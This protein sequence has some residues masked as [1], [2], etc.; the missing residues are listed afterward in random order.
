MKKTCVAIFAALMALSVLGAENV[1]FKVGGSAKRYNQI[2]VFNNT[3]ATDFDC[4][5]FV[6]EERDGK[7]VAQESLGK[8]HLRKNG[9]DDTITV[10]SLIKRGTNLGLTV[11]EK[12][13]EFSYVIEYKNYPLFDV[14]EIKLVGAD[15]PLGKEF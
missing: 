2:K 7:L 3:N 4:E 6:L 5:A 13:G 9:G 1:K 14:I 15:S 8:V 12:V 11:P 10:V